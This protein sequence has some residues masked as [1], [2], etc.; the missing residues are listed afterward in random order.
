MLP[1]PAVLPFYQAALKG[2]IHEDILETWRSAA[3][4]IMKP[5]SSNIYI[6][7]HHTSK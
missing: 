3:I 6:R 5:I 1:W 7:W 4:I 2:L